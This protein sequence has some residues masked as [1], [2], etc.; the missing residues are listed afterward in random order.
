M[1]ECEAIL[2]LKRSPLYMF[3]NSKYTFCISYKYNGKTSQ[4]PVAG[5]L[6]SSDYSQS[7]VHFCQL[8]K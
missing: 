1:K 7:A 2:K 8:I 5:S 4:E 3:K 6:P